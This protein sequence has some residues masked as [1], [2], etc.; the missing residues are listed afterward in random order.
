MIYRKKTVNNV[1]TLENLSGAPKVQ[2]VPL[3]TWASFENG[4][5]PSDCWL[6]AGTTFDAEEYPA[7]YM[8]LGGN[9]VPERFDASVIDWENAGNFSTANTRP[10]AV[11]PTKDCILQVRGDTGNGAIIGLGNSNYGYLGT[12]GS[13]GML[14]ANVSGHQ[15]YGAGGA[16]YL[17]VQKGKTYYISSGKVGGASDICYYRF[18]DYKYKMFI[19]ATSELDSEQATNVFNSMKHLNDYSTTETLTGGTWIDGKPIYQYFLKLSD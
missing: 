12:D 17:P 13:K 4:S 19:K 16:V 6:E 2:G 14:V 1:A 7:L 11:T 9:V 15:Q 18:V 8:Y 3:G 5:A 10:Y